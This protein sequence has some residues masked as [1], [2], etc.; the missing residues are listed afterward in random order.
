VISEASVHGFFNKI[1]KPAF[2]TQTPSKG[3]PEQAF[4]NL[5]LGQ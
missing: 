1:S 3:T 5:A 4:S 2:E